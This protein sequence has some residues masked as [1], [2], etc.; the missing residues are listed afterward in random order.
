MRT[1]RNLA[2]IA[3]AATVLAILAPNA[4]AQI[5]IQEI[6]VTVS[7]PVEVPNLVLPIG[8]YVF[9]AVENGRITRNLNSD[10]SHVYATILT[11]PEERREPMDNSAVTLTESPKGQ[12]PRINSWFFAGESIGSEFLYA[13]IR[14][15]SRLDAFTKDAGHFVAV[16]AEDAV[17]APVS[18]AMHV[19]RASVATGR[20][21]RANF[22][23]N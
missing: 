3:I 8:T 21:F 20:F 14:A 15:D 5:P 18:A 16:A 7:E 22:L 4:G 13:G 11:Q 9:Q 2:V 10:E 17:E 6:Q 1:I 23:V 12:L 19:E